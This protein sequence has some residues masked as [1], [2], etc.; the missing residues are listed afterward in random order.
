MKLNITVATIAMGLWL[1]LHTVALLY[2][3]QALLGVLLACG[4]VQ[5]LRRE[6]LLSNNLQPDLYAKKSWTF[7]APQYLWAL[8]PCIIVGGLAY[9]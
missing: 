4:L 2:M 6:W 5:V 9:R 1:V 8:V 3:G 7:G